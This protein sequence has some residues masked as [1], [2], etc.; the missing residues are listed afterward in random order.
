MWCT[1]CR[2]HQKAPLLDRGILESF[3]PSAFWLLEI[4]PLDFL[5]HWLITTNQRMSRYILWKDVCH[6]VSGTFTTIY[7]SWTL[8]P[9]SWMRWQ[10]LLFSEHAVGYGTSKSSRVP[11][12]TAWLIVRQPTKRIMAPEGSGGNCTKGSFIW[13]ELQG[14]DNASLKYDDRLEGMRPRSFY[15]L[16]KILTPEKP[17]TSPADFVAFRQISLI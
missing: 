6:T 10:N 14:L 16:H 4:R 11:E 12:S 7:E 1:K 8:C 3:L 13:R 2:L 15:K 9:S 5:F 17:S